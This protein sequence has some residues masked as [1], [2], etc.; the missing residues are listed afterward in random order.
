MSKKITPAFIKSI[1]A[2][3]NSNLNYGKPFYA[4]EL[5]LNGGQI[6]SLSC[7]G[8]IRPTGNTKKSYY[9]L[10]DTHARICHVKEWKVDVRNFDY[11]VQTLYSES[12]RL[13]DRI[14]SYKESINKMEDAMTALRDAGF[15]DGRRR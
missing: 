3:R 6:G 11:A 1:C 9:D 5:G 14:D 15:N 10:D 4:E 8:V 13:R 12:R 2:M 7:A